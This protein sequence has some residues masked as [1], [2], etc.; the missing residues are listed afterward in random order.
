[1]G[2]A[3]GQAQILGE[4]PPSPPPPVETPLSAI[5]CSGRSSASKVM[6]ESELLFVRNRQAR[7]QRQHVHCRPVKDIASTCCQQTDHT[8]AG[9]L[10]CTLTTTLQ[11]NYHLCL[12]TFGLS[13]QVAYGA[14]P[15]DLAKRFRP[16][17]LIWSQKQMPYF[18]RYR[19][20]R[21]M[22]ALSERLPPV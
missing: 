14:S 6:N 7:I 3:W 22:F 12:C 10:H 2:A 8:T 1:M 15:L 18:G 21:R 20:F 5:P 9:Q 4:Y 13:P 19:Q 16:Q 17:P 11:V